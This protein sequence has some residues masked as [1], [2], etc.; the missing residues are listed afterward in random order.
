M[1]L[2]T[3]RALQA[4]LGWPVRFPRA[5]L[6]GGT[7]GKGSTCAFLEAVLR[8][9][10]VRT[11]LFT[12]PH[13]VS[14]RERIRVDGEDVDEQ[15]VWEAAFRVLGVAA[16]AGIEPSFFEVAHAMASVIFAEAGVDVAIWEVG[17]G[18]RL[19]ATN[20]CHPEASAVVTVGLDHQDVLGPTLADIA[21]EKAAI[22]RPGRPA[23]TVASGAALAALRAAT[24]GQLAVVQPSPD[25]PELP[26]PGEHQRHNAALA[27]A[28]ASCLGV[29]PDPDALLDVRWPG[30][31][32]RIGNV[33]LDCAHNPAGAEALAAFLRDR[34]RGP[35]HL[36]FGAMAGKD[37]AG[38]IAHLEPLVSSVAVVTPQYPR[39][40]DA[41]AL[42]PLFTQVPAWDAGTV[43]DAL[44]ALPADRLTLV[45]G[46]CFLVG[47]ARALMTGQEFP[48]GGLLTT[49]R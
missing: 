32:E 18:G 8:R 17:L 47:E 6:V 4:A 44:S 30:R 35:I 36:V 2:S 39:R 20:V 19:D 40:L 37:V 12:S 5:V 41:S 9:A 11:G 43:E 29:E 7:N 48:E 33:I 49:A 15:T 34:V 46:S 16:D 31:A 14:F 1:D 26:L 25:L 42:V 3:P 13:L 10:G 24:P 21:R 27:L 23:L 38:V 45:T 28:L 22:F